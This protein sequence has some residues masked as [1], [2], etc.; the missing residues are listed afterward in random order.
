MTRIA[1]ATIIVAAV[2]VALVLNTR[3]AFAG[4]VSLS[5]VRA[6]LN[7]VDDAAG[8][9]QHEGGT[10]M[11][12]GIAVGQYSIYRRVTNGGTTAQ[13]TAMET[14]TLFFS[15]TGT[16]PQNVTLQGAH[17]FSA[18]RFVGSVSAAS[19][20]YAWVKGADAFISATATVGTSTLTV[21]WTGANQLSLP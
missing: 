16:P 8:R 20:R 11:K 5:L 4:S 14:V 12:G 1:K 18:G 7:N 21:Q 2:L 15:N 17:S 9:W 3:P 10:I 19:N 13:N 6:T